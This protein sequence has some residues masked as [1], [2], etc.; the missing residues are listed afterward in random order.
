[1]ANRVEEFRKVVLMGRPRGSKRFDENPRAYVQIDRDRYVYWTNGLF[2]VSNDSFM[3]SALNHFVNYEHDSKPADRWYKIQV[4]NDSQSQPFMLE[5]CKPPIE[6]SPSM[7]EQLLSGTYV[8]SVKTFNDKSEFPQA[9]H[10]KVNKDN[11]FMLCMGKGWY[12]GVDKNL[13]EYL[14]ASSPENNMPKDIHLLYHFKGDL[15]KGK[16]YRP[17]ISLIGDR[18]KTLAHLAPTKTWVSPNNEIIHIDSIDSILD[19]LKQ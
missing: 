5:A 13:F 9:I 2:I 11:L 12:V 7:K 16:Q 14:I 1:M 8:T 10:T 18:N 6:L 15:P 19:E 4:M 17:T 3:N